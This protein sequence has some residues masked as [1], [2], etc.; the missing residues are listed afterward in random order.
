[1]AVCEGALPRSD[2][3]ILLVEDDEPT[4]EL[5]SLFLGRLYSITA[6][7]SGESAVHALCTDDDITVIVTDLRMPGVNGYD[8]L[9]CAAEHARRT[10]RI[11]PA[12]VVTGHGTPEDEL[13]HDTADEV[14]AYELANLPFPGCFGVFYESDRPTKNALEEKWIQTVQEKLG[15]TTALEQL[16][17]TFD[18]MK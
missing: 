2:I 11:I 7:S 5:L 3:R 4:L 10:G 14:A 17:K 9:R 1:M 15:K 6:C 16:Q 8:V 18:R 12:V 13:R